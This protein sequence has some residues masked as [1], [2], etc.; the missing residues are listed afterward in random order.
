M[1]GFL[2]FVVL[3][4]AFGAIVFAT[5]AMGQDATRAASAT[6]ARGIF[7]AIGKPDLTTNELALLDGLLRVDSS[8]EL[9]KAITD[10]TSL[11]V[12]DR[13]ALGALPEGYLAE[14]ASEGRAIM[15]INVFGNDLATAADFPSGGWPTPEEWAQTHN[16]HGEGSF[17]SFMFRSAPGAAIGRSGG[18]QQHFKDRVFAGVLGELLEGSWR[19]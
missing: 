5:S 16:G 18:G 4:A 11:L 6:S 2:A 1:R 10:E 3:F 7:F 17:Y 9:D 8:E 19:R 13:S 12:I 14:R 15:G